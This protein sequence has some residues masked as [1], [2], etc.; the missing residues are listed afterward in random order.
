MAI[1]TAR[2]GGEG[3]GG[4]RCRHGRVSPKLHG[5]ELQQDPTM[6]RRAMSGGGRRLV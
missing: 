6:P 1:A 4:G 2:G 5:T 3:G